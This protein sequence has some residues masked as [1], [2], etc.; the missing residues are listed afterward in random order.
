MKMN[1]LERMFRLARENN[2]RTYTELIL[3]LP[4]ETRES[5]I[6]GLNQLLELGQHEYIY[7]W[8]LSVI[9]TAE[10]GDPN[11]RKRYGIQTVLVKDVLQNPIESENDRIDGTTE[12]VEMV[13]ATNTITTEELIDCNLYTWMISQFHLTGI[14][15]FVSKYCRTILGIPYRTFYDKMYEDLLVDAKSKEVMDQFKSIM[16]NYFE[17]G[18]V[19]AD[20][21]NV[22]AWTLPISFESDFIFENR[23]YF[24]DVALN[25]AKKLSQ[26]TKDQ[27]EELYNLQHS[28]F[29]NPEKQYPYEIQ[30]NV[31]IDTW[32]AKPTQ[33]LIDQRTT[34]DKHRVS[35]FGQ[36]FERWL[37]KTE[38]TKL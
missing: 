21:K 24:I 1:D 36:A 12:L 11:Y 13:K 25:V 32:E 26:S 5:F 37:R 17:F 34:N 8:L 4:E 16:R 31:D 3:G 10:M 27:E 28:Y 19:P 38:I 30:T 7:V 9:S 2:V 22:V 6:D 20:Y 14:S 29:F 18:E 23:E 15:E 33:Y 35:S